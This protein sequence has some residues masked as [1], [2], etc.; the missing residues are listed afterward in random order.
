MKIYL[1]RQKLLALSALFFC[2]LAA[3]AAPYAVVKQLAERR[4]PWL[5]S[6]LRFSTISAQGGKD[7]FTLTTKKGRVYI[8][9][10]SVNAATE[11]LSWYLKYYCNRS[12]S[13]LGDNLAPVSVLPE[14]KENVRIESAHRY[15]YALNYCTIGYSMAFYT[16]EDWA[17]ELDWMAL[18]GVNLMLA[19]VGMEAV[20]QNT[21]KQLN[22]TQSEI[23]NFI[24]HP[25]FSAWWLMGNLE[26]W[27]GPV[28]QQLI[29]QQV[30]LQRQIL[31]RM[32][33]LGIQPVIQGFYGMVPA[34]FNSKFKASVVEQGQWAGGFQRPAFLS[35]ADSMFKKVSDIYYTQMNKLYGSDLHFFAGD[36]FHEGG[37]STGIDVSKAA[38]VIQQ[39]MQLHFPQSTWILQGWQSNPSVNLLQ[40]L[41]KNKTLIIELFG[42]NTDNWRI[43]KGYGSTPFVWANVSNFG[44]KNGLY[45]KLQRFSDEVN[46]VKN[47]AYGELLFG[48]GIIPEGINNN[49]VTYDFMLELGWQKDKIDVDNWI[50]RYELYRYGKRNSQL[51]Q[52]W[53][54]LLETVY[55]SPDVQQEGP[56]ESIF[57]ARPAVDLK[58]VSSWGT[59]KRNYDTEKFAQ[60]VALFVNAGEEISDVETYQADRVDFVRQ[61][62]AN[63]GDEVYRRMMVALEEKDVSEFKKA[64]NKFRTLILQQDSLLGSNL[65]FTLNRWLQQAIGFSADS[66]AAVRNAKIQITYWGPGDNPKTDL[67]D[68]AHKEWNGLLGSLYLARWDEF[69]R[70]ETAKLEGKSFNPPNYFAMEKTWTESKEMYVPAKISEKEIND[71][72]R[73]ILNRKK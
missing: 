23:L 46:R 59:R 15:R 17:R 69:I 48:I 9:A 20:W 57:C 10:S 73:R 43:R 39:Q 62:L 1:N 68:Y 58:S 53:K 26:G 35:P 66:A 12:M 16:W 51:E 24:P 13:H 25:A 40:G 61:V 22:Y 52:A 67:H 21:L 8:S 47:S 3:E 71:L 27:G 37:K 6:A 72:I 29:D 34:S 41:D 33:I 45:G 50:K 5:V 36:P 55:S 18:N 30:K 56:S 60:A 70:Q 4:V 65:F 19:P 32:K 63:Q 64:G 28:S 14:V 42:E 11:G 2:F 44:E 7:I 49:P 31:Q 54:L 38:S